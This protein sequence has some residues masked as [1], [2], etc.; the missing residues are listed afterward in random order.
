M[1]T[2]EAYRAELDELLEGFASNIRGLR[3]GSQEALSAAANLHRTEVG[4]IE[5]AKR[6]PRLSTLMILADALEVT[7]DDLVRGLPVPRERKPA[8]Q[9]MRASSR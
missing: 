5:Q 3:K 4:M 2:H 9:T 7:L 6:E 1:S 8:P